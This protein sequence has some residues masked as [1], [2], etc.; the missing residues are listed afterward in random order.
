L[1]DENTPGSEWLRGLSGDEAARRLIAD[2]PNLLPEGKRKSHIR[3]VVDVLREPMFLMLL[4]AGAVYLLLGDK[5]EA[6]F[7]LGAVFVVIGLT[8]SQEHKTQRALEALRELSA[9]RTL[10][11]RDGVPLRVPS[12]EVVVGDILMLKEGDRIVADSALLQGQISVDESTLTGE[13]VPN[14][15]VSGDIDALLGTPGFDGA[16]SVFASTVVTKGSAVA[17]VRATGSRT[18]V[19]RIGASL[20]STGVALSSLQRESRKVVR[21]LAFA[22]F[23][24][25]AAMVLLSWLWDGKGLRVCC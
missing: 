11:I 2:G 13:A 15:K 18:A 20:E 9:P 22:G 25:A 24:L 10:V 6:L 7:L 21:V 12:R 14:N 1:I 17:C 5:A 19:G 3:I 4:A 23:A 16:S 8:I